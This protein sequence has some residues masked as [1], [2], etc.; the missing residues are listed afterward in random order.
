MVLTLTDLD[1]R[2][3]HQR[4]PDQTEGNTDDYGDQA[5]N[6]ADLE[7]EV[8]I[9]VERKELEPNERPTGD[10]VMWVGWVLPTIANAPIID[11]RFIINTG[12]YRVVG[13]EGLTDLDGVLDHYQM[14]LELIH[15]G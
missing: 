3:T 9:R 15:V 10:I 1:K 2:A 6:Y 5:D 11:D 8:P 7:L 4:L 13:V 12:S 14:D